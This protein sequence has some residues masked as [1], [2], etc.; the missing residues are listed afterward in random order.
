R[1]VASL[2]DLARARQRRQWIS[3]KHEIEE[4]RKHASIQ[5]YTI[6]EFTDLN[7]ECNG[8][9]DM[10][11]NKKIY[12]DDLARLQQQDV[13]FARAPVNNSVSAEKIEL[14]TYVSRYSN[15]ATKPLTIRCHFN[16]NLAGEA[17]VK[18]V[19]RG[20]VRVDVT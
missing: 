2:N 10:F 19:E 13:I 16:G 20:C 12:A 7:W 15:A 4:I 5:G 17:K 6:T 8:L 9:L 14:T 3:L 11:R 1:M 18:A